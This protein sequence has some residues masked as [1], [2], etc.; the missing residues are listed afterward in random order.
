MRQTLISRGAFEVERSARPPLMPKKTARSAPRPGLSPSSAQ[1]PK[2]VRKSRLTAPKAVPLTGRHLDRK[3]LSLNRAGARAK[4]VRPS[5]GF[6][7]GGD[8][9]I[10][11][12]EDALDGSLVD[13]NRM[14][15]NSM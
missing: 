10:A 3:N 8:L 11:Y 7:I 1:P 4:V 6:N 5:E 14:R 12:L 13:V 2:V 15:A 9:D